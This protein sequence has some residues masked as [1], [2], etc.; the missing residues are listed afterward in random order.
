MNAIASAG[1]APACCMCWPTTDSGFQ[2]GTCSA[3]EGDVVEQHAPRARQREPEEHVVGDEVREVVAL[4]R[5][6]GDRAPRGC[7]GASPTASMKASSVN[8]DGIVHRARD[9]AER[10]RRRGRP[11][12][13]SSEFTTRRRCRAA[14]AAPRRCRSRG[15]PSC[16]GSATRRSPP[17]ARMALQ[18][19][20]VVVRRAEADQLALRPGAA[21]VHGGVD[22][23]RVIGSWPGK[24]NA[25]I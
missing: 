8:G 19:R 23:A 14:R 3:A 6:A 5:R 17:C 20:V 24:P 13:S 12:M 7:R 1:V 4:V 9:V 25:S 15:R 2:R 10:R 11:S 18:P 22:A 16:T 21:A